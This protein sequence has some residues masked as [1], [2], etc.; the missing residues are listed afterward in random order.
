MSCGKSGSDIVVCLPNGSAAY[1][2]PD[3]IFYQSYDVKN[4][5]WNTRSQQN[6]GYKIPSVDKSSFIKISRYNKIYTND[7]P[8]NAG[9]IYYQSFQPVCYYHPQTMADGKIVEL[10]NI[11]KNGNESIILSDAPILVHILNSPNKL[12]TVQDWEWYGV[13]VETRFAESGMMSFEL[14][15]KNSIYKYTAA[16]LYYADGTSEILKIKEKK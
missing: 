11:I 15:D 8:P 16:I 3:Y 9:S 5:K 4:K 2:E 13:E 14:D 10:K 7:T 6:F 12:E 1:N